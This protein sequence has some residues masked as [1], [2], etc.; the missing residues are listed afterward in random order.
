MQG[1][2][3]NVNQLPPR[4]T[5]SY[6]ESDLLF[7]WEPP[8]DSLYS[9]KPRVSDMNNDK[10][11][12]DSQRQPC[13]NSDHPVS[14]RVRINPEMEL[15]ALPKRLLDPLALGMLLMPNSS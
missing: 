12:S 11:S 6:S 7:S 8:P 3:I 1:S 10:H 2:M 5:V 4:A 15:K 13:N 9:I 14:D